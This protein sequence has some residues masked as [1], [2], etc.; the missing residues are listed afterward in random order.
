MDF[1][2]ADALA[3]ST[4][5][6]QRKAKK[7]PVN[8]SPVNNLG[9]LFGMDD[10]FRALFSFTKRGAP[11]LLVGETG[12]GKTTLAKKVA[13]R[14]GRPFVRVNLD[15][16]ITPAELVGRMT[17]RAV[18]GHTQTT[19]EE[20]ILPRAMKAG[21]VLLLDEINAAL[22]DTLLALHAVLE[23]E[24][25]LFI[26]ETGEEVLP[27]EGFAVIATMNPT[28]D[29]AGTR[30]LNHAL[31]SRFAFLRIDPLRGQTLLDALAAHAPTASASDIVNVATVFEKMDE[32]RRANLITSRVSIR[33]CIAAL[34]AVDD[35]L[36]L[37]EAVQYAFFD[38]LEGDEPEVLKTNGLNPEA[39]RAERKVS[40][41]FATVGEMLDATE[42][43]STLQATIDEQAARLEKLEAVAA[44]I[45]KIGSTK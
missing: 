28:N 42:K 5:P 9:S 41:K 14:L 12:T 1:A 33:Q 40:G 34:R 30:G 38:R 13:E 11:A 26:T 43:A 19:F 27:R 15:G 35:G 4:T 7:M 31:A 18:D 21:A 45:E 25:R 39:Y 24:P 10:N 3:N 20:G 32:I 17:L 37:T 16:A 6:T 2:T 22:P 44:L 36:K 8:D 29:Y 23:D